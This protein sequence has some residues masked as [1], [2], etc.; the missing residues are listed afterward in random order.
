MLRLLSVAIAVAALSGAQGGA[1]RSALETNPKG[2]TDVTPAKGWVRVP[3]PKTATLNPENQWRYDPKLKLLICTGD[4]GH[5]ML[6]STREY[7][8]F[9]LHVEWRFS[10]LEGKEQPRYNSGVMVRS[11][12]DAEFMTQAQVGPGPNVWLFADYP[13]DG[14]KVRTNLRD[15]MTAERVRPPGEW[16]TYE[17]TVKGPSVSLWVNGDTIGSYDKIPVDKGY[18]GLEAEGFYI[19]F[20]NVKV[21][22]L[23]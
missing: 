5:E 2:W 10:R 17:M 21:K 3:I 22:E 7:K 20:A 13:V 12:A 6:R 8:D 15:Q 19:E 23:R 9:I 1:G 16:N 4:K 18:I 14:K 11:S